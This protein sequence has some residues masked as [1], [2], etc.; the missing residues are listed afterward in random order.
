MSETAE[1]V[2]VIDG[3]N[4]FVRSG[5]WDTVRRTCRQV[6]ELEALPLERSLRRASEDPLDQ[7]WLLAELWDRSSFSTQTV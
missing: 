5:I 4:A 2:V 7:V 1:F 6:I 3:Y